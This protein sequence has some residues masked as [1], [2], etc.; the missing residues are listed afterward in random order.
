MGNEGSLK[1]S[2]LGGTKLGIYNKIPAVEPVKARPMQNS[3]V[4]RT[5]MHLLTLSHYPVILEIFPRRQLIL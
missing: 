5:Y 1:D 2:V 3:E 4:D